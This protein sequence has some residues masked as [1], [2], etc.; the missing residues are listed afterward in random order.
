MKHYLPYLFILIG[1]ILTSCKK[2]DC[3]G[4]EN[5]SGLISKIFESGDITVEY[6]YQ[7]SGLLSEI[8]TRNSCTKHFYESGGLLEKIELYIDANYYGY[9]GSGGYSAY[10]GYGGSGYNYSQT[11]WTNP[12]DMEL[13]STTLYEYNSNKQLIKSINK[14]GHVIIPSEFSYNN[15]GRISTLTAYYENEESDKYIEYFY[16]ETGNLT[17]ASQYLIQPDETTVLH[18][19]REYEVDSKQNPFFAFK[20][21]L[22]P[23]PNT[24]PNNTTKETYTFYGEISDSTDRVKIIE[25]VYEYNELGYPIKMDN[26]FTFEYN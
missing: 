26:D 9:G 23:G 7:C 4:I 18:S 6:V 15:Q 8:R 21:L 12:K 19:I 20:K 13:Y 5:K 11:E 2:E 22:I 3:S 1:L 10:G 14:F 16:D 17:K 25:H 24:N